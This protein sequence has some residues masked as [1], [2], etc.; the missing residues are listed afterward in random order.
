MAR[1]E[2]ERVSPSRK[3]PKEESKTNCP[4]ECTE[5]AQRAH[6]KTISSSK[7]KSIRIARAF[8]SSTIMALALFCALLA[9]GF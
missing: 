6:D 9:K 2:P 8:R 3:N 5:K 7:K 4:G 1:R